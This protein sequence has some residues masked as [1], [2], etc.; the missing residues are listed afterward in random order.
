MKTAELSSNKGGLLASTA[1]GIRPAERLMLIIILLLGL[2]T[3]VLTESLGRVVIW[4]NFTVGIAASL[5]MVPVGLYARNAKRA[6]RLA[7]CVI[8]VGLYAGFS[9]FVSI[10]I[11]A[12]YPLPFPVFDPQLAAFD[13]LFGYDWKAFTEGLHQLPV[14]PEVLGFLYLSSFPQLALMILTLGI[15]GREVALHRFLLI[16]M[17]TL[18]V[19][20]VIWF[21]LPSVGPSG[22]N[23]VAEDVQA[24]FGLAT[25]PRLG[26]YLLELIAIGPPHISPEVYTGVIAFPSF[27]IIMALMVFWYARGTF[28]I[29]PAAVSGVGMVPATLAHGGHYL[30]DLFAGVV[31]FAA[32]VWLSERI[33]RG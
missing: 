22:F 31:V 18:T 30:I 12:L 5:L 7:A 25:D 19:T 28:L 29:I 4:S 20:T 33:I 24:R 23:T 26:E 1:S 16:G 9:A 27:H 21:F 8:G 13:A 6:E 2:A 15:L 10:F 14:I 32:C 11:F 17:L 3:L